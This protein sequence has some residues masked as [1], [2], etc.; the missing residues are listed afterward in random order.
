M[1]TREDN[2][3]MTRVG[4]GTPM[5]RVLREFWLPMMLSSELPEAD[6]A[7]KRM[8]LLGEDLVVFRNTDGTVGL[9]ANACPHR[10]ASMF[11]GRNEE[12]GLRCVY[13]GWKFDVDGRCTDLPT[14]PLDSPMRHKVRARAWPARIAG[15]VLWV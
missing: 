2:E 4:P 10:G 11:F 14:E 15:G 9:V 6:G 3:L 1:L 12:N 5:G 13:H 8:R 7:P